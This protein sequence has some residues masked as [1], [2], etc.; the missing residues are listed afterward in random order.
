M[1]Y[2]AAMKVVTGR[3]LGK[4][5][6]QLLEDARSGEEIIINIRGEAIARLVPENTPPVEA[7]LERHCS[8][9]SPPI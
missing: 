9:L 5:F 8:K 2:A 1:P 7:S 6:F 3:E 4:N